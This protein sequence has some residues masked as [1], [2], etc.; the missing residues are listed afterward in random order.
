MPLTCLHH[1]RTSFQNMTTKG[2]TL[3]SSCVHIVEYVHLGAIL[4]SN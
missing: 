2:Q 1:S 3:V 4:N